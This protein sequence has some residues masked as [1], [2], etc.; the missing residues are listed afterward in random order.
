MLLAL[1]QPFDAV[2]LPGVDQLARLIQ[3]KHGRQEILYHPD[4]ALQLQPLAFDFRNRFIK[5]G[6]AF[7]SQVRHNVLKYGIVRLV[8]KLIFL[9]GLAMVILASGFRL[10]SSR[11]KLP[12][13]HFDFLFY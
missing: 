11:V 13:G 10:N 3:L 8:E 6:L 9:V 7:D 1:V 2:L 5:V 4:F 12:K